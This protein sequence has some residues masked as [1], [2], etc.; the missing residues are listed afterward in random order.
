MTQLRRIARSI[1]NKLDYHYYYSYTVT[2]CY[3]VILPLPHVDGRFPDE[4][5]NV[6]GRHYFTDLVVLSGDLRT[7]GVVPLGWRQ[8]WVR[9]EFLQ[10]QRYTRQ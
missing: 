3:L 2:V 4:V 8:G 1:S 6:A 5:E 7:A 9:F 10:S